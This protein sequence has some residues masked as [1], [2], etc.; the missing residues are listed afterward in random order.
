ME[1]LKRGSINAFNEIYRLYAKKLLSYV[2]AA[3]KSKEDAEEIVHD[4]FLSLWKNRKFLQEDK[5][6]SSLLFSIAYKRRIDFFRRAV[7]AP[8][9]ED[10][11]QFS[12][13][14]AQEQSNLL[15]YTDFLKIFKLAINQLPPR[16][17]QLVSMSRLQGMTNEEIAIKLG[18]S[19]K[20]VKNGISEGLKTLKEKL[21]YYRKLYNS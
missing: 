21:N 8:V 10:F 18:V 19:S 13:E 15:D 6:L 3:T 7:K 9:Y 4:I 17:Q 20:T 14:L 16:Q 1:S 2:A 11:M 12:N 5:S